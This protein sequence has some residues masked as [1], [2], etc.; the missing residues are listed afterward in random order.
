MG[1]EKIRYIGFQDEVCRLRYT[2][3][4][5]KEHDKKRNQYMAL[6]E[7]T[8]KQLRLQLEELVQ[9]HREEIDEMVAAYNGAK[10]LIADPSHRAYV[11]ELVEH[12]AE[13]SKLKKKYE[14]IKEEFKKLLDQN[15]RLKGQVQSLRESVEALENVI[16]SLRNGQQ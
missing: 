14:N 7:R 8:N 11:Y 1:N 3:A 10:P 12:A 16:K 13:G 5:Y 4:K 2:I 6:L 9:R 15:N